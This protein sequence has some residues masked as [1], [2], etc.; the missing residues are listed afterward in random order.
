MTD[1]CCGPHRFQ[2]GI[3]IVIT[4]TLAVLTMCPY[5]SLQDNELESWAET[6]GIQVTP[7]SSMMWAKYLSKAEFKQEI[8][9]N[10]VTK[11]T[12]DTLGGFV[13][14]IEYKDG[15][16]YKHFTYFLNPGDNPN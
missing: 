4:I 12:Y 7:G 3:A 15:R 9:V 11:I 1:I 2:T 6:R 5:A 13:Y 8:L 14:F 16:T 10:N